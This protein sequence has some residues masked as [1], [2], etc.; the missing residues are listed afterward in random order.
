MN[1]HF[2][3]AITHG[4]ATQ[5]IFTPVITQRTCRTA[6]YDNDEKG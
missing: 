6:L 5:L 1:M 4:V 3:S 2:I